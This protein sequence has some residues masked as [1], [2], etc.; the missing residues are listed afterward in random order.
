MEDDVR[1]FNCNDDKPGAKG[2]MATNQSET[3]RGASRPKNLEEGGR[4]RRGEG[5]GDWMG[6]SGGSQQRER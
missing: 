2:A 5:R 6:P 1:A 3:A 4:E